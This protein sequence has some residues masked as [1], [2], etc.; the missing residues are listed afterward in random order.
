MVTLSPDE[1]ASAEFPTV[2]RG[3]FKVAEVQAFLTDVAADLAAA[4][5]EAAQ[6]SSE[7]GELQAKAEKVFA[8]LKATSAEAQG[9]IKEAEVARLD[10]EG[11]LEVAERERDK[12]VLKAK[13]T[14]RALE[15]ATADC[16]RLEAAVAEGRP[17]VA[18]GTPDTYTQMGEEVAHLLRSA[19]VTAEAVR[20]EA[21]RE[22]TGLRAAADQYAGET[23]RTAELVAR[24]IKSE[25]DEGARAQLEAATSTSATVVAD[26]TEE[27]KRLRGVQ[28]QLREGLEA[29]S[30]WV[31]TSLAAPP[32]RLPARTDLTLLPA[33]PHTLDA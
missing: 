10:L 19:A 15:V 14:K 30:D 31:Q 16:E 25:A 8:A 22:A 26:A 9:A 33:S 3:G 6:A 29:F 23:R 28:L 20:A 5:D 1:V 32:E 11:R 12:A 21:E 13:D 27:V 17:L 2:R 18:E 7:L 4:Q 24:Q